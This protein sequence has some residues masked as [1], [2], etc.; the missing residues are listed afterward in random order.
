MSPPSCFPSGCPLQDIR[1]FSSHVGGMAMSGGGG[2]RLYYSL[3]RRFQT[4]VRLQALWYTSEMWAGSVILITLT[5]ALVAEEF[6]CS[7]SQEALGTGVGADGEGR[8]GGGHHR[9]SRRRLNQHR[10][11]RGSTTVYGF[12]LGVREA[13]SGLTWWKAVP[14]WWWLATLFRSCFTWSIWCHHAVRDQ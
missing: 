5:L 12:G 8:G 1:L 10:W 7:H 13:G 3:Y 6:P 4:D 9:A 2:T 14:V 11:R